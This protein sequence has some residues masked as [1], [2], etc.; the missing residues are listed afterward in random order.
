MRIIFWLFSGLAW[1]VSILPS[2][3]LYALSGFAYVIIHYIVRYRKKIIK[4]NL[5]NSFPEFSDKQIA[6]ITRKYYQHL[7]DLVLEVLKTPGLSADEIKNRF[8]F[9]NPEVLKK[10]HKSG[11]S[12]IILTAHLGNW[13][14]FGPGLLLNFPGFDGFAV[15]KPLSNPYFNKYMSDLRRLH[16]KDS[17]IPFKQT[18]RYMIKNKEKIALSIIAAD[19]TP[20]RS[21]IS[22][23]TCFLNQQT[24]FF[25][26]FE[27]ISKMLDQALVFANLYRTKRGYYEVEFHLITEDPRVSDE[28][29]IILEY[30]RLLEQAIRKRPY[31]WLW[32][33]RRWKY[34]PKEEKQEKP[35]S[36]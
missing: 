7:S 11:K 1:L 28:R 2:A 31:N 6:S 8:T 9:K 32:S 20:H 35:S 34:A 29:E 21:E 3:F 25:T 15:V 22:F 19:Q 18:L 10:I 23:N 27:K 24:P 33:H 17:L 36:A 13:E 30:I 5:R 14:W 12:V 26:G 4:Q 16:K